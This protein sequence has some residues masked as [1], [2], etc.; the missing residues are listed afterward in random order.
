M[1][2]SQ[3]TKFRNVRVLIAGYHKYIPNEW[4]TKPGLTRII[5]KAHRKEMRDQG[6]ESKLKYVGIGMSVYTLTYP[7]HSAGRKT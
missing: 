2:K 1:L 6:L 4:I 3:L 7:M 5:F